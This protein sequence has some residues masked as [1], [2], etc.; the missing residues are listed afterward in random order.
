MSRWTFQKAVCELHGIPEDRYR[1]LVLRKTLFRRVR[2]VMPVV[3][4]LNPDFLHHEKRLVERVGAA[5]NVKEVRDE[6]DFYQHKFVVNSP[7]KDTLRFRLSGMK[8]M[9]LAAE[10]FRY[11]DEHLH[12]T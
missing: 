10:A 1:G 12:R 9:N 3:G 8:L 11:A 2:L 5:L 6:I 4:V 7:L